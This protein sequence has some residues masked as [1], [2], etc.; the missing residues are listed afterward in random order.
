MSPL[1]NKPLR[2][3]KRVRQS[4]LPARNINSFP[5]RIGVHAS[6]LP[7]LVLVCNSRD[8][9]NRRRESL[10]SIVM[11][12]KREL[13][14]EERRMADFLKTAIKDARK[15]EEQVGAEIN[16]SQGQ[17]SHW[18]GKRLPVPASRAAPLA[19]AVGIGDPAEIS[20]A[21]RKIA[22]AAGS[23]ADWPDILAYRQPASLGPGAI[24]DEYAE[25]HKL[26]FRTD[27]LQKK[28]L[29]ADRLG[30][31]YGKGDSMLPRIRSGDAIL[32]DTGD[33]A[34]KDGAL[35]VVSY[36]GGLL[37]KQLSFLGGRWFIESLNKD[38]PRFR[39]PELI[40]EHKGF[41]IHGRVRWI[42]SWED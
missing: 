9:G 36:G 13:T 18:T 29:R 6:I 28:R 5:D 39:K 26:K 21:Y 12:K 30:V 19:R 41:K 2:T 34:P 10:A 31:V 14:E 3:V 40:D 7:Q 4:R 32:F 27:S 38:E 23:A 35:F 37:A 15:T 42:G 24:P 11:T 8:S 25:T 20:V 33:T 16:V 17:V 22:S 1:P